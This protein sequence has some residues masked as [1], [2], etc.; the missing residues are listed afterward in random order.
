M[1]KNIQIEITSKTDFFTVLFFIFIFR[2]VISIRVIRIIT[3][4]NKLRV[5]KLIL[6]GFI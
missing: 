1:F 4:V 3:P 6:R 2:L 5:W